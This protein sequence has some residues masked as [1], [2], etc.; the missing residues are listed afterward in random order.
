F[1]VMNTQ[2]GG[3]PETAPGRLGPILA[4][5]SATVLTYMSR[6]AVQ[7]AASFA[8]ENGMSFRLTEIPVDYPYGGSTDFRATKMKD[9]FSYGK[10]CAEQGLLWTT[11]EQSLRRSQSAIKSENGQKEESVPCPLGPR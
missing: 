4:R 1:V 8:Q 6:T 7:L 10:A 2:L 9:L 3:I 11:P 5:S